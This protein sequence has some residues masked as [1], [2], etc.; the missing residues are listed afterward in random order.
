[1][2]C[3][4]APANVR[5]IRYYMHVKAILY[6][7]HSGSKGHL[8]TVIRL[9]E[10]KFDRSA[11]TEMLPQLNA[12]TRIQEF[13]YST[14]P[15]SLIQIQLDIQLAYF[16]IFLDRTSYNKATICP[17]S[18]LAIWSL[19]IKKSSTRKFSPPTTP[20]FILSAIDGQ[21]AC[22]SGEMRLRGCA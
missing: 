9:L 17:T 3:E 16:T 18:Y 1:M 21:R 11:A 13:D 8:Q 22:V 5:G 10:L 6:L 20:P 19:G 15:A 2:W 12:C 7:I 4:A 14:A